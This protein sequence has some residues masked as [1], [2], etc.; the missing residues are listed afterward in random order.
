MVNSM[1]DKPMGWYRDK[2]K[3]EPDSL[4]NELSYDKK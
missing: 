2:R 4:G 3:N 1:W